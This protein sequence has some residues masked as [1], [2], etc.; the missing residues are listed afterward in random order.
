MAELPV[1]RVVRGVLAPAPRRVPLTLSVRMLFGGVFNSLIYFTVAAVLWM[2]AVSKPEVQV[3]TQSDEVPMELVAL[4]IIVAAVPFLL[5]FMILALLR[6]RLLRRGITVGGKL[7]EKREVE[8]SESSVW[9]YKFKYEIGGRTYIVEHRMQ[10]QEP[11]LEDDPIEQLVYLP[12]KPHR[13]YPVD[14]LPGY[15]AID[16][17]GQLVA[18]DKRVWLAFIMPA[19]AVTGALAVFL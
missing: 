12:S 11:L 17:N 6:L 13:A 18:R 8:G 7:I 3:P 16:A 14:H 2:F 1:A 4:L 5:G 15:P 9:Y 19:F 10:T